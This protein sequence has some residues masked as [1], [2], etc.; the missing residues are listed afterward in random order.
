MSIFRVSTRMSPCS[1]MGA[2]SGVT[3]S[4]SATQSLIWFELWLHMIYMSNIVNAVSSYGFHNSISGD[5]N[6]FLMN[7]LPFSL[8]G[9]VCMTIGCVVRLPYGHLQDLPRSSK[10]KCTPTGKFY[11]FPSAPALITAMITS[12]FLRR[13]QL[14]ISSTIPTWQSNAHPG[15]FSED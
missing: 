5:L 10:I 11:S 8:C 7:G 9:K 6:H 14:L 2:D 4:A 3:C 12:F 13:H 15:T 1:H